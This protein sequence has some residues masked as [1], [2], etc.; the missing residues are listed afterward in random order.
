MQAGVH[1]LCLQDLWW[2]RGEI[3][4][5]SQ[6]K[7]GLLKDQIWRQNKESIEIE[8]RGLHAVSIEEGQH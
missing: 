5:I 3:G 6:G 7:E 2:K 4:C 1:G 8:F